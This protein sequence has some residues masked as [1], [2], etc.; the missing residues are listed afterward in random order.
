LKGEFITNHFLVAYIDVLGQSNKIMETSTYPP[1]QGELNKIRKNLKETSD[2]IVDLR[3]TLRKQFKKY[4]KLKSALEG[5]SKQKRKEEQRIGAFTTEIVGISDSLIISVPLKNNTENCVPI[6]NI[7]GVFQ[8]ISLIYSIALASQKPVRGGIDIGWGTYLPGKEVYGSALVKSYT[9]ETKKAEYPRIVI[10]K[11]LLKYI[12]YVENFKPQ[13]SYGKRAKLLAKKCKSYITKDFD[14]Q[15]I[16]DV[17]GQTAKD[18]IPEMTAQQVNLGY[19][20]IKEFILRCK[21]KKDLKLLPRYQQLAKYFS[22][23]TSLWGL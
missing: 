7:I 15:H 3:D 5:L 17:I 8:G 11:S 10:G 9:L 22:T 18:S 20:F 23:K 2:Y 13:T 14:D 1:S 19:K 12:N 16:V 4:R 6:N 21:K